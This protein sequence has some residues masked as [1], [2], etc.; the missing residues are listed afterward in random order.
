MIF[1]VVITVFRFSGFLAVMLERQA[2]WLKESR[3]Y[4]DSLPTPAFSH[5]AH[6]TQ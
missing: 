4:R 3:Q 5:S 1:T 2:A 6:V